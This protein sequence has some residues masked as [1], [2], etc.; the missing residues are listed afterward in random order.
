M[1]HANIAKLLRNRIILAAPYKWQQTRLVWCSRNTQTKLMAEPTSTAATGASSSITIRAP[2]V[3]PSSWTAPP[4]SFLVGTWFVTHSTLPMWKTKK[5]VNIHYSALEAL[6]TTAAPPRLSDTVSY[7]PISSRKPSSKQKTITGIDTPAGTD[8]SVWDW[9]GKGWLAIASSHWEV[10]GYGGG[11][12][13]GKEKWAVT[14]FA[15]TLFTPAGI[16]I[17]SRHKEGLSKET[18]GD[19]IEAL[20]ALEVESVKQLV[21]KIFVVKSD[22]YEL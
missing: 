19:V 3:C 5:N 11:E 16:D 12:V 9:R 22:F 17:Y 4:L 2:T 20:K 15:K 1:R 18:L 6:S 21:E 7:T 8:T 10:L 14:Y 13:E